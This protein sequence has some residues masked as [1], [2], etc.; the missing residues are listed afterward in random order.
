MTNIIFGKNGFV[1]KSVETTGETPTKNECDLKNYESTLSYLNKFKDQKINIINLAAKV[2]GVLYNKN[3]NVE[4]LYENTLISLNLIKAIK[5]LNLDCYLLSISSVCAYDETL[6]M[7]EGKYFNGLPSEN[8]FGYGISKKISYLS[9]KALQIDN[10]NFKFACLIPTNMYGEHDNISPQ[11]SH[12]VPALFMKMLK[13]DEEE[14]NIFGNANNVRNFLYVKDLG[15]V[16]DFFVNKQAEGYYNMASDEGV[17]IFD[18]TEKIKN[19]TNCTKK[20][21]F[22]FSGQSNSRIV[23]NDKIKIFYQQHGKNLQITPLDEGLKNTYEWIKD[24]KY[25][26]PS[27]N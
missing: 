27:T 21:N 18:L 13:K 11:F 20:I 4:M 15:R 23:K 14:A 1:G 2:A 9:A 22:N 17:S 3:H 12:V 19:I 10:P 6:T 5:E 7:E 16:I 24:K 25:E 8:N 26:I